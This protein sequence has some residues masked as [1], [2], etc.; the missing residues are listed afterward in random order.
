M[1][2][3]NFFKRRSM[4]DEIRKEFIDLIKK[5]TSGVYDPNNPRWGTSIKDNDFKS[6]GQQLK[7]YEKIAWA[8]ICSDAISDRLNRDFIFCDAEGEE[9]PIEK[10]DDD[11]KDPILRGFANMSLSQ[12]I[13]KTLSP[14]KLFTGNT[15][16]YKSKTTAY[17]I[18][19]DKIDTLIP[20]SPDMVKPA[21]DEHMTQILYYEIKFKDGKRFNVPPE[22]IIH[23]K[24]NC[25][26]NP[27]IGIGNIQKLRLLAEGEAQAEDYKNNF[28]RNEARPSLI[29]TDKNG[30]DIETDEDELDRYVQNLRDKY[31][32][33]ANS[34][35]IMYILGE[36][37]K[38]SF[39]QFNH[40]DMQFVEQHIENRQTIISAF[41]CNPVVVGIPTDVNKATGITFEQTFLKNKINPE[42]E[43]WADTLNKQFIHPINPKIYIKF[44]PYPTGNTEIIT[45]QI[46]KGVLTP[47]EGRAQLGY[48]FSED[49]NMDKHYIS[50]QLI[51]LDK[52]NALP[53]PIE[54]SQKQF[55]HICTKDEDMLSEPASFQWGYINAAR[56]SRERVEQKYT[57]ELSRFFKNQGKRLIEK[58]EAQYEDKK[59]F[60]ENASSNEIIEFIF[61]ISEEDSLMK[62]QLKKLHTSAVTRAYKDT[63][64]V[65]GASISA[66]I[67]NPG[68]R[69]AITK[70]SVASRITKI[71]ENTREKV[72]E[73][74]EDGVK[75]NFSVKDFSNALQSKFTEFSGYRSR[76][77]ARTEAMHAYDMGALNSYKELDVKT[78]DLV[79]CTQFEAD[80]DCGAKDV[81]VEQA[82]DLRRHPNCKGSLAPSREI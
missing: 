40:K 4:R 53:A 14:Q 75:N 41:G 81:P 73:L 58:L 2:I 72:K 49:E 69:Q 33:E 56:A 11:I 62:E 59:A 17:G 46:E 61:S 80:F 13:S 3:F 39:A 48:S 43:D 55:K 42:L 68:V 79:G 66:E 15:Y 76:L 23:F 60:I 37:P 24:Q 47:N 21:V 70:L 26:Y 71:T 82:A 22:L 36:D 77:I 7:A 65:T 29:V 44:L 12:I 35:K 32:G 9:I 54:N 5:S 51:P 20:L 45:N 16:L 74:I 67:S 18:L 27:F 28:L 19:R 8:S 30:E 38:V 6:D 64:E 52:L 34:G 1:A 78:V 10:L 63:G 25:I 31:Q 50:N 57:A